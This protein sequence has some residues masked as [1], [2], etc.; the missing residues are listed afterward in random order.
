MELRQFVEK[1]K[2]LADVPLVVL[3]GKAFSAREL[4]SLVRGTPILAETVE[5]KVAEVKEKA[6][7]NF[8]EYRFLAAKYFERR[9]ELERFYPPKRK[10]VY[11]SFDIPP[12][13]LTVEQ[14]YWHVVNDTPT[15]RML[16]ENF[17]RLHGE[18]VRRLRE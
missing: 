5:G 2:G 7:L 9:I 3:E 1:Y 11:A 10:I 17:K 12:V 13:F 4:L 14:A 16:I 6:E 18:V 8:E 15:G